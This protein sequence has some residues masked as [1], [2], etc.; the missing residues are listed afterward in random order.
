M[1]RFRSAATYCDKLLESN[2]ADG[3]ICDVG[4]LVKFFLELVDL[5]LVTI[6]DVFALLDVPRVLLVSGL[7]FHSHSKAPDNVPRI[8]YDHATTE[9]ELD[10]MMVNIITTA[11]NLGDSMK[12]QQVHVSS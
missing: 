10:D 4:Q 6:A 3:R 8:R 11:D 2:A 9:K 7:D 12:R 5:R 1:A